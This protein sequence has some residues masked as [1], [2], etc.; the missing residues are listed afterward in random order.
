MLASDKS[1]TALLFLLP[2][3]FFS[4]IAS[5]I[6]GN[7]WGHE[8]FFIGSIGE[9]V[10]QSV[11][12]GV[13]IAF[14]MLGFDKLAITSLSL[15]VG[16]FFSMLIVLIYYIAKGSKFSRPNGYLAPLLRSSTPITVSRAVSSVVGSI[17]ALV[18]P[19]LL[20]RSGLNEAEAL[21][22]YGASMGMA[23]P[24]LFLPIT[25][26]G[27]MSFVLVPTLS[28]DSARNDSD[29]AINKIR[30]SIFATVV[31]AGGCMPLFY[32]LGGAIG[33]FLYDNAL[34]GSFLSSVAWILLPLSVE[35]ITSS[36]MNSLDLEKRAFVNYVIG[37]ICQFVVMFACFSNFNIYIL[38]FA[39]GVSLTVTSVLNIF[40]IS[41]KVRRKINVLP[42]TALAFLGAIP[43]SFVCGCVFD[44]LSPCPIVL[45]LAI[46]SVV[47][48]L[49][50]LGICFVFILPLRYKTLA[51]K[52]KKVL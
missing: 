41:K 31:I 12:F 46:A 8:N 28:S 13:C 30:S 11:R 1:Y 44:M 17:T 47:S 51:L 49:F 5:A 42:V 25:V 18:V 43:T 35:S 40:A 27:S 32:S 29:G 48:T 38:G 20:M 4:A 37:A 19:F 22:Q 14:F 39:T 26:V 16:C 15:S 24:L 2:A 34:A 3:L 6:K 52:K 21:A 33:T 23:M 10:E 9:I 50:Y 7:L 45:A 36:Q